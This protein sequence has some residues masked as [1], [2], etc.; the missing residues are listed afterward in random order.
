[1]QSRFR[2]NA[3]KVAKILLWCYL[4][5]PES[6]I[7][8]DEWARTTALPGLMAASLIRRAGAWSWEPCEPIA[9]CPESFG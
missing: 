6:R 9:L 3:F 2:L 4:T 8:F 5:R 1:M 7:G